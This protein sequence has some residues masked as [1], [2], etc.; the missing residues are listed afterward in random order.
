VTNPLFSTYTQGENRVTSTLLAV[1]EHVNSRLGEDILEALVDE[2]D[3]SLV[4]FDNQVTGVGSV[5]DAAIRGST[6]LWFETKTSRGNVRQAQLEEHLTG[7]DQDPSDLQRLIVLTPDER[8]PSEVRAIDD[9]RLVWASF[10]TLVGT[11]ESVLERDVGSAEASMYV[12]TEREAF[13]LRELMRFIYDE[14]LVSGKEDRVL[15]V[16]ARRAWDEYRTYGHYF[17]QPNR[18]F[19]P[20]SHLAFYKDGEIKAEVPR[21][22]G[23]VESI[24]LD[25]ETVED[26]PELSDQ[27]EQSLLAAVG[28]MRENESA[29]YGDTQK[30]L[31][32]EPDLELDRAVQN[33]KTASD[34]NR[35]VAFVQGHR[36]VS[37]STLRESPRHTTELEE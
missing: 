6:A 28:K 2:S 24:T 21:V 20:V 8:V 23:R 11:L 10:D 9:D 1:L 4:A 25:E 13:L 31:F 18:S 7:L 26:H 22:T 12:P 3:L 17:C 34:S 29:R 35:T 16:A 14:E 5:P 36:Y 27:Q 32:L 30:V 33:D 37:L 19:K 15:V